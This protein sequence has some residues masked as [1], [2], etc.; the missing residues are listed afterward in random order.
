MDMIWISATALCA[1]A[2]LR[3]HEFRVLSSV[4]ELWLMVCGSWPECKK[5]HAMCGRKNGREEFSR[6]LMA[7]YWRPE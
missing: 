1:S 7:A 2:S 6:D 4:L 3:G 5:F